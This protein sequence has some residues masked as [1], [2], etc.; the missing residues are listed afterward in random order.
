MHHTIANPHLQVA[1]SETGAELHSISRNLIE[2][3]AGSLS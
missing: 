1:V 3:A 2:D